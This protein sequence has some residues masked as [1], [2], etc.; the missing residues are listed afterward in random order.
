MAS[1]VRTSALRALQPTQAFAPA[2]LAAP[3]ALARPVS[4]SAPSQAVDTASLA[5][6]PGTF[7]L[8]N[9]GSNQASLEKPRNG[10]EYALSTM[11]KI[12]NWARQGSMWPMVRLTIETRAQNP[13]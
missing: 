6:Q 5:R 7:E 9:Q 8:A 13:D 4:T 1:L 3:R 11:D 12:V 2:L 10:V